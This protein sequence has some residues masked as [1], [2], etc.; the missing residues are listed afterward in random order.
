MTLAMPVLNQADNQVGLA[1]W[2]ESMTR[3][4]VVT[5]GTRGIGEAISH[6]AEGKGSPRHCQLWRQ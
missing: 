5:G 4:A 2:R 6:E 3:I 1:T